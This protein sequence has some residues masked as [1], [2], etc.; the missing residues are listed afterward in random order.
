MFVVYSQVS[1]EKL[2]KSLGMPEYSYYFVLKGFLPVLRE[3][4]EVV[5]V[6]NPEQEV[7]AIYDD[8]LKR[9]QRC[10][11]LTFT[12]PNKSVVG[13]RCPTVCVFAWEFDRIPDEVWDDDPKNDWRYVLA[14]HGQAIT[15]SQYAAAA[16]RRAMGPDFPIAAIPVPV[17]D[18][19][20]HLK[21]PEG[22]AL[23]TSMPALSIMGNVVDSRNY[24]ITPDSFEL[25]FPADAFQLKQWS[26]ETLHLEFTQTDE[27]SAYLGGFYQA[28][29]WGTWSRI[30]EPWI[31]LPYTLSGV[32]HLT[33]RARGYAH[34]ADKEIFVSLGNEKKRIRLLGDFTESQVSFHLSKPENILKFSGLDLSPVKD[35]PDPRS[36]G[37]GLCSISIS[38]CPCAEMR[39]AKNVSTVQTR[40][41][42]LE[43]VVYTSVFNPGDDRKNWTDIVKAFGMAF[44][45]VEDATLVLKMT[46]H[47]VASFL[48][49]FHFL[50]QQMWPFKCRF[51]AMHGYL[52]S[53]EYEKLITAT[54]FYV[55][56]SRCE[57][58]CLPL[59]EY[60]ACGK[61]AIAPYNTALLDYIDTSSAL[62]VKSGI[63]PGIWPHD[64]RHVLRTLRYR[65]DCES[66]RNAYRQGYDIVKNQPAVFMQMSRSASHKINNFSSKAVVKDQLHNF[67]SAIEI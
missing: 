23:L 25:I 12:P 64:P 53:V 4:G 58:L 1:A 60:M 46:H 65:I 31:I 57:G 61:P 35:A 37:V 15:L 33:I 50:L 20:E 30:E 42:S 52:D 32:L 10:V 3:L 27:F 6:N 5:I 9:G 21:D 18:E 47:S 54:H 11:F 39:N 62:I 8:C 67:F 51:V 24:R 43:G 13:L 28:E 59:M 55:N 7:D 36:M 26:G 17:G 63:E 2:S 41:V 44:Q 48:G 22:I 16:V 14:D 56:A 45:D 34:N 49:K 19:F 38:G 29:P 66:L 40:E